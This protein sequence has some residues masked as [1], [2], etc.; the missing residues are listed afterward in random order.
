MRLE[1]HLGKA[2]SMEATLNKL[3]GETDYEAI[4][5]LCMLISAHYSNAALHELRVTPIDRDIR[6]TKLAG[7]MKR[8]SVRELLRACEAIEVLEKLRPRHIYG[9]GSDGEVAEQALELMEEVKAICT[10]VLG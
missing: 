4:I 2:E 9:R 8:R 1:D 10:K 5:E 7:E 3:D 6:H